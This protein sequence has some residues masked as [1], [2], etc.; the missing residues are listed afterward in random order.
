MCCLT[1]CDG[2][3]Y[4]SMKGDIMN[5]MDN[6][7]S[8]LE[9]FLLLRNL[10]DNSKKNY[11]SCIKRFLKWLFEQSLIPEAA[12]FSDIRQFLIELRSIHKLSPRTVNAYCSEIKFFWICVLKKQWD[13]YQVPMAKF[14]SKLPEIISHE[15]AINLIESFDNLRDKTIVALMYGSGLRISEACQLKC[16]NINRKDMTILIEKSKSREARLSKL[17]LNTLLLLEDYWRKCGKPMDYLFPGR[18]R[19]KPVTPGTISN[20][21]KKASLSIGFKHHVKCHSF[22]HAYALYLYNHGTDLLTIQKLLGHKSI[23]ST[24]IYV[25]L[26]HLKNIDVVSPMDAN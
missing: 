20:H 15:D 24:T 17:S 25:R 16:E 12:T 1:F 19:S 3:N 14:D 18:D 26:S 7:L 21:L 22:R 11:I 2:K 10:S 13:K 4:L 6:Y 8:E 9:E 23:T 5:H